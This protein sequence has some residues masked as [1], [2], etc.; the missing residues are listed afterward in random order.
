[1]VIP[2]NNHSMTMLTTYDSNAACLIQRSGGK[3][4]K[5]TFS[6]LLWQLW[7]SSLGEDHVTQLIW[8]VYCHR[9][10]RHFIFKQP[11]DALWP[12][13][14]LRE[15]CQQL[16]VSAV[17]ELRIYISGLHLFFEVLPYQVYDR[18]SL[19]A[20]IDDF[21]ITSFSFLHCFHCATAHSTFLEFFSPNGGNIRYATVPKSLPPTGM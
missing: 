3:V 9:D 11:G 16:L 17:L 13:K 20:N 4:T 10:K 6:R 14:V 5:Q 12:A 8:S 19:K 1:M 21:C 18:S 2:Q 15:E 7:A